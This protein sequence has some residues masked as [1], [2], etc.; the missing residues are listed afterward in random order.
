MSSF[1]KSQVGS[2]EL[3]KKIDDIYLPD[4]RWQWKDTAVLESFYI[5]INSIKLVNSVPNDIF[6]N[7]ET[8]KNTLLY[9]YFS[10]RLSM[11][12]M[13]VA[14]VNLETAIVKKAELVSHKGG[15][16]GLSQKL[17]TAFNHK[18]IDIKNVANP[19]NVPDDWKVYTD[20]AFIKYFVGLRN[21]LAHELGVLDLPWKVC[22]DLETIAKMINE[23]FQ[24]K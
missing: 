13:L 19:V 17:Q 22:Q 9:S 6:I 3:F 23:L 8:A 15:M 1:N 14:L 5:R 24:K 20:C 10:Y 7:F 18:W 2:V 21:S 4:S 12:A 16:N 11:A